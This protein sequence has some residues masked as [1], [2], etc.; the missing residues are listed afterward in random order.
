MATR[1]TD[2]QIAQAERQIRDFS[3]PYEYDTKEFPIEV[4]VQKFTSTEDK[5]ATLFIPDYQREL[6]WKPLRQ[7]KFIES[8]FLG[9]PVPPIFTSIN[10]DG[11]QEII[12]GSQRIRTISLFVKNQLRLRGL[13]NLDSLNGFKFKD[14]SESRQLKFELITVRFHVITDKAGLAIRADIFDRLNS[15]GKHLT[16]SEIRKG[17]FANNSY[18]SF[19]R[20][21]SEIQE[22]QELFTSKKARGEAEELVLRFFAYSETYH[23]FK[24][25]VA[26]F[27]NSFVEE[28]EKK[29]FD[30]NK[31]EANF[32]RMLAFVKREF[33][34]GF[35][36]TE[37]AK[38]IPRVRF[39][40]IAVGTH[41]ALEI[42]PNLEPIY[43]DWLE[44]KEFKKHTTSDASNNQGK[45]AGRIEFVRDCLL[46][47]IQKEDLN[48]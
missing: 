45:L 10:T 19:V 26:I 33:S 23:E 5:K 18:Y 12:D 7:S 17:A 39:E 43:M 36:K 4:I 21:M 31:L 24:H 8:L 13:N 3:I 32:R 40:S 46:N 22:F 9:V 2:E 34:F 41:L 47:I 38:A 37:T 42:N 29:G 11:R 25:D 20:E 30:K 28:K 6:V 1:K 14:L 15:N 48:Y 35:N 16:P 27:L 44:S